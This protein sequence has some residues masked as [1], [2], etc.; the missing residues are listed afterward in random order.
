MIFNTVNLDYLT[1]IKK[2]EVP[3][4]VA[5]GTKKENL[6]RVKY[7]RNIVLIGVL[8]P[9]PLKKS[10]PKITKEERSSKNK[11]R[12]LD[13]FF[14]LS[15]MKVGMITFLILRSGSCLLSTRS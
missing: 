12:S 9:S 4:Q 15:G 14:G 13:H 7:Y 8:Q 6:K 5:I 3:L 11:E 10:H 1:C 2:F